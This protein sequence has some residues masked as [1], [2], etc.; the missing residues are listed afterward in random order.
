MREREEG[1]REECDVCVDVYIG[2]EVCVCT[3]FLASMYMP[4]NAL[5]IHVHVHANRYY[6]STKSI[7]TD[8]I[9]YITWSFPKMLHNPSCL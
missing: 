4:D 1:G 9:D 5:H 2:C 6:Y 8:V 7:S 3:L